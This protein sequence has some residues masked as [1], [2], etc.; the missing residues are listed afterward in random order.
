MRVTF[1]PRIDSKFV[2]LWYTVF[3]SREAAVQRQQQ[4]VSFPW[5]WYPECDE[6]VTPLL[7][8]QERLV[9]CLKNSKNPQHSCFSLVVETKKDSVCRWRDLRREQLRKFLFSLIFVVSPLWSKN[10]TLR[11]FEGV[12]FPFSVF[13]DG[14]SSSYTTW[15]HYKRCAY[16]LQ[17]LSKKMIEMTDDQEELP[18][19]QLEQNTEQAN[20]YFDQNH[21]FSLNVDLKQMSLL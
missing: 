7:S 2:H 3:G 21:S 1:L 17:S 8:V 16:A 11:H 9:P 12:L 20:L 14:S 19:N 10:G 15:R 6:R 4:S 5:K 13:W 18:R